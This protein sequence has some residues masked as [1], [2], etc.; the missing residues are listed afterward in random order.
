MQA[1]STERLYTMFHE[2]YAISLNLG[3]A[4]AAQYRR[5][6]H[7]HPT[8]VLFLAEPGELHRCVRADGPLDFVV[9]F[10]DP[11]RMKEAAGGD[12]SA[13]V[14]WR[15]VMSD[16][17]HPGATSLRALAQCPW[18]DGALA[19]ESA[20]A[21]VLSALIRSFAE[22]PHG[23]VSAAARSRTVR[24]RVLRARELLCDRLSEDVPLESVAR[25][26]ELSR[27]HLVRAFR[28][29]LGATPHAYLMQVR[30]ARARS[31]LQAGASATVAAHACGFYD[32]SHMN[33][34]FEKTVGITPHRYARCTEPR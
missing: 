8:D 9:L 33:R 12:G 26:V 24:P 10:V 34:W 3:P 5:G 18:E 27:E 1:R 20:L 4:G 19:A 21:A 7:E 29:E 14:H 25:E 11:K 28:A 15:S 31:M 30:V 22:P 6:T 32:Q 17:R 2:R 16:A 13:P 23:S